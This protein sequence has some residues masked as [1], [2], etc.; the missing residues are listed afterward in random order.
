MVAT[1]KLHSAYAF[2]PRDYARTLRAHGAT[3]GPYNAN[4]D[5]VAGMYILN[6][7]SLDEAAALASRDPALISGGGVEIRPVHSGGEVAEH[8]PVDAGSSTNASARS[9]R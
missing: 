4:G 2:T 8:E 9:E 5:V 1:G 3:D 6:A 7:A